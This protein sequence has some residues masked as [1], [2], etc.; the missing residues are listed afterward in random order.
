LSNSSLNIK[1][2]TFSDIL[3]LICVR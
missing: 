3:V 1:D 2:R